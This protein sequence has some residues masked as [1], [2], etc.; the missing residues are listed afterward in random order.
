MR[1]CYNVSVAG[2]LVL[3]ALS[4]NFAISS[5]SPGSRTANQHVRQ[6]SLHD[7][8]NIN[9]LTRGF[10]SRRTECASALFARIEIASLPPMAWICSDRARRNGPISISTRP[11][12]Q[13]MNSARLRIPETGVSDD[14]PYQLV[15]GIHH[16]RDEL[17][18]KRRLVERR[19]TRELLVPERIAGI[20]RC[21]SIFMAPIPSR[22]C[23][24]RKPVPSVAPSPSS[25][26]RIPGARSCVS[27]FYA[28]KKLRCRVSDVPLSCPDVVCWTSIFPIC[29]AIWVLRTV[30][31]ASVFLLHRDF[32]SQLYALCDCIQREKEIFLV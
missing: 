27:I 30:P 25:S 14:F 22:G 32:P 15:G 20:Q 5:C 29:L 9:L 28:R 8:W 18:A 26:V 17:F 7:V 6:T 3:S 1:C 19:N 23:W 11:L 10:W 13:I 24:R 12:S 2:N 16:P 4:E 21:Y 31:G